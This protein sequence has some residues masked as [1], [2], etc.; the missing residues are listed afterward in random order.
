MSS[1][2]DTANEPVKQETR[3]F[4]AEVKQV[5]DIVI[6]SLYTHREIFIRELISNASDALEKMRHEALT[7][8]SYTDKD[9]PYEIKIET[10]KD[11]H[12]FSIIDTGIGMTHSELTANLGTIARS[13]TREFLEQLD[14]REAL[15]SEI[16]GKFGVGFYSVFMVAGEVRVRTRSYR[17]SAKGYEWVSDGVGEYTISEMDG[18]PRGTTIILNLKDDAHEY[19]D[20]T[21]VKDVITKYSNFVPFPILVKNEKVNTVQAIWLKSTSEVT[22]DEYTEF[23][24]FISNSVEEPLS[25]LHMSSDAPIQLSALLY[26]PAMNFEQFG[27]MKLKP[28]VNLYCRKILIQQHTDKLLPEYFRFV[29]GVVDSSDL[30]LNISRETL[31]DN[32]IFRKLGKFLTKRVIRHLDDVAKNDRE[33]Y[34]GIW[35]KFGMFLKEGVVSDFD[36]RKELADLLRFRSSKAEKDEYIS[37]KEY[38]DRMKEGQ[39]DIYYLYGRSREEIENGPYVGTFKKREIEVLYLLEPIDDFVMTSLTDYDGKKLIS[40]D[41]A[42]IE[43]PPVETEDKEAEQKPTLSASDI[44]G[45]ASWMKDT[46]GDRVKEVRESKR[47]MD[48]PAII[49]NPDAAMTTTMRRVMKAAGRDI[50]IEGEKI[51]E[52]NTSHPLITRL[53]KLRDGTADKGFLQSCVLQ[54]YDNALSEAGLMDDPKTMVERVYTIMEKALESAEKK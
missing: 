38:A 19:E 21:T 47:S 34:N 4:K 29:H 15:D 32:L 44:K 5:L 50:G 17:P 23:F 30:P 3:Q 51:L 25:R 41:S 13:G 33:K 7:L 26:I 52:I 22:D 27:L 42:D 45:L 49:V 18:L 10:D 12:T 16:I 48:R 6:H 37:L 54:I 39:K 24:K 46:I 40:A 35:E 9:A 36:N 2:K 20:E 28:S 14:N 8:E 53:K 43:L 11:N 1:K 31:Q